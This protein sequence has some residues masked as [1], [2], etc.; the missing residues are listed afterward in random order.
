[1][2]TKKIIGIISSILIIVNYFGNVIINLL[3]IENIQVVK[4]YETIGRLIFTLGIIG[5]YYSLTK[6]LKIYEYKTEI[7]I[8]NSFIVIEFTSF[9][10]KGIQYY[11]GMV[12]GF[13]LSIIY[14][15]LVVLFI[16]FGIRMLQ[17]KN[18]SFVNLNMLKIFITLI[19]IA[20]GLVFV[21][22]TI[23]TFINNRMGFNNVLFSIYG[24]PYIWGLIFFLKDKEEKSVV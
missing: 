8:L 5:F 7:K 21:F 17:S 10:L 14:I 12:P 6:Y 22:I 2:N 18:E 15:L 16:I 20:F 11:Y 3:L 13:I 24:I 23:L 19:F 4:F 1:M 9:I